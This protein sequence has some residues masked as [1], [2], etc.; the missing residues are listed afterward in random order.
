MAGLWVEGTTSECSVAIAPD[1]RR[2]FP[3]I[4]LVCRSLFAFRWPLHSTL[5]PCDMC[6]GAALLYGIPKIV[7]GENRTF[8]GPEAYVRSRGVEVVV[9]DDA[10]CRA[11]MERF[12]REQPELWGE[13][14]GM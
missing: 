6:S 5:S 2:E 12:V 9:A 3:R 14:V 11:M 8:Q 13:D 1:E 7:V 4:G 10:R